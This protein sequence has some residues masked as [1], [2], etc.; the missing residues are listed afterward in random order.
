MGSDARVAGPS[1]HSHIRL[2]TLTFSGKSRTAVPPSTPSPWPTNHQISSA[3]VRH[4]L[5]PATGPAGQA[6]LGAARSF[7]D[8]RGT[9]RTGRE[10]SVSAGSRAEE[11][12]ADA[13]GEADGA[14]AWRH[15]RKWRS[16]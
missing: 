7:S 15:S 3:I 1:I 8:A 10:G 16:W 4:G 2:A 9:R 11:G 13:A 14:G 5:G 12:T 6:T